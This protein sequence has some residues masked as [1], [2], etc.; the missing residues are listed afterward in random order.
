MKPFD[1]ELAKKGH[2]VCTRGGKRA[3]IICFDAE[4]PC[5]PLIALIKDEKR[6]VIT[7]LDK[8]GRVWGG[9]MVSSRD[10][11]MAPIKKKK[12]YFL[13]VYKQHN[14]IGFGYR[15]ETE[16]DAKKE[17]LSYSEYFSEPCANFLKTIS[18][19]VEE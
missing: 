17:H 1:L 18:F 15:W 7:T 13:N 9:K 5:F 8:M 10:L 2:P 16:E 12:T 4:D 6:E 11:F 19:E 3:R 14:E